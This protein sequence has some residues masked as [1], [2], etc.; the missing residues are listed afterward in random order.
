MNEMIQI[1][2]VTQKIRTTQ[3]TILT[4]QNTYITYPNT[5]FAC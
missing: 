2:L 1:A 4:Y 3:N 5:L